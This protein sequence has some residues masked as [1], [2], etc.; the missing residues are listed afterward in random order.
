MG[1]KSLILGCTL[2]L[3]LGAGLAFKLIPAPAAKEVIKNHI[4]T[5]IK[6]RLLPNGDKATETVIVDESTRSTIKTEPKKNWVLGAGVGTGLA[7]IP[8]YNVQLQYRLA[9][10]FFIGAQAATNGVVAAT[11]AIEF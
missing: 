11:L 8:V 9:G 3:L 1:Y 2:S 5:V 4:V 6:E 7:L 10:P